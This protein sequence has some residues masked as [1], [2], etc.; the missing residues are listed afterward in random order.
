MSARSIQN[1]KN[2]RSLDFVYMSQAVV[3]CCC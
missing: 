1:Y 2:H 3:G